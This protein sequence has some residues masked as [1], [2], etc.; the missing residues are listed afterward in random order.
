[1]H[2]RRTENAR[3]IHAIATHPDIWPMLADD[4][5]PTPEAWKPVLHAGIW[6]VLAFADDREQDPRGMFVFFPENSISWQVHICMLPAA[7]GS[8][9][10]ASREVF[11][12]LWAQTA[13]RRI[14]AAVPVWNASAIHCALRAGMTAF[15]VNQGSSFKNGRLH[16]Q[17]MLG[18][19]K[20]AEKAA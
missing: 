6:Y 5:T 14:T 16:H 11:Q 2:F 9:A 7:W 18:V 19:S 15:G 20:P 13:C 4:L 12:W 17:L 10:R 1:M 8:A 3:L